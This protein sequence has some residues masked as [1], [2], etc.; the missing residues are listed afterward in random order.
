[1][2]RRSAPV[3][4]LH[5]FPIQFIRRNLTRLRLTIVSENIG[6]EK[7]E[8]LGHPIIGTGPKVVPVP[9]RTTGTMTGKDEIT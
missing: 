4:R 3:T 7:S 2:P 9:T 6:L 8:N 1:M 5:P